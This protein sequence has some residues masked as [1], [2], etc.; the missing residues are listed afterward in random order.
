[1]RKI[2]PPSE[3]AIKRRFLAFWRHHK[4]PYQL[5]SYGSV[6]IGHAVFAVSGQYCV[7]NFPSIAH[8]YD[9]D[10]NIHLHYTDCWRVYGRFASY[11]NCLLSAYPIQSVTVLPVLVEG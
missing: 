8:Q 4:V 7:F 3:Q 6:F 10:I 9:K 2:N 1:M 11:H 5:T